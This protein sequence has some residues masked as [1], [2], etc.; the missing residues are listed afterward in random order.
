MVLMAPAAYPQTSYWWG[1]SL[2]VTINP[3]GARDA[4]AQWQLDGG[5]YRN[6]GVTLRGLAPGY[7]TVSFKPING[8]AS[9]GEERLFIWP[10]GKASTTGT[11]TQV[12]PATGALTVSITPAGAVT[13]GAQWSVDGGAYQNS[14]ATVSGLGAGSHTVA[15][16]PVTGW[17]A[18]A[19]QTVT[20]V[21]GQT[22]S[23]AG[24]YTQIVQTGGLTVTITPAGAVTA[25]AQWRVDSGAYQNSGATVSGLS[26]GSHTVAFKPVTGWT[27]PANQ[28]VTIVGGQTA[29]ASGTYTQ[30]VQ[31]GG[32]T[33]SITPAGAVT[34]GAQWRVDSGVYQNSGATVSGLSAGSHT[35]SFKPVTGWGTP[36]NQTVTIVGGQTATATGAYTLVLSTS[37]YG[38]FS[39]YEGSKTCRTC[40]AEETQEVHASHHYQ[41]N[42]PTPYVENMTTGGKLGAIN[43]FCTYPDISWIG[44]LTN[45]AGAKVDGGCAQCHVGMGDKPLAT[46]SE[47]QLNNIDCLICHS[48][49][50]K[51]KVELVGGKLMFVPAPEK[52][53]VDALEAI[54]D[55]HLPT[56][57]TCLNCHAY[58]GGGNNNKRGD[59]EEAHRSPSSASFDV[60]MASTAVGG[61]GLICTDCH[62]VQNHR[63]AG[64]GVDLRATD[65]D[66][67]VDCAMCHTTAPHGVTDLD[68]HTRRVNCTVCHIPHF[69]KGV[70][71]DMLR[72]FSRPAEVDVKKQLY[73]PHID[74][75]ANVIP[76]YWFFNGTS[77]IYEFMTPAIP[78]EGGR[79]TMAAPLGSVQDPTA[80][81]NAFKYHNAVQA[82]DVDTRA[83]LPVKAGI[84]F[85]TGDIDR[86][87]RQGAT[88]VGLLLAHGYDFVPTERYMGLFHEVAPKEEALTCNECHNGGARMDFDALGYARRPTLNGKPLCASCHGDKTNKW[89]ANELFDK[90]HAKHVRDK[91]IN[92]S[93]C[94]YFSS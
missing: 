17:T 57:G 28:A 38:R 48:D 12:I 32:L 64:R 26:A 75:E 72:D 56:N 87:I 73:E 21:G 68:K 14:G 19:N 33:V 23:A 37:H 11:Y 77:Y 53:T 41:W 50:Y 42:S 5:A 59:L 8:W 69:A 90:V 20:L 24:T 51:R 34:A 3:A 47:D 40:H 80:K 70:S 76:E 84:L 86:A 79:V 74:R 67:T 45:L 46:A 78:N 71:T 94:H 29:A 16:K 91:R 36:L 65:L 9:P 83:L 1:G 89:P 30:V 6:S 61:A 44:Q 54:T 63:I 39:T 10:F 43:D 7:H 58:A 15:F 18:P 49:S 66:V 60:H 62:T 35:V 55:I 25:G 93:E 52:M 85:Q 2:T 31:T 27:A 88:D 22:T 4:G 92:C 13:A 81:I 82:R